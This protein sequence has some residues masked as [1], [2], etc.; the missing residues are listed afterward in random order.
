MREET[1]EALSYL[2]VR[3]NEIE[4]KAMSARPFRSISPEK[5]KD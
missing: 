2:K 4:G 5:A 3:L 1:I